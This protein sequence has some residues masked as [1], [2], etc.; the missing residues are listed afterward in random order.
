MASDAC[1]LVI[2]RS[3]EP[4]TDA[5][6][7]ANTDVDAETADEACC[8]TDAASSPT[9]AKEGWGRYLAEGEDDG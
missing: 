6:P 7:S 3:S 9:E 5:S 4:C 8:C 2:S 1:T